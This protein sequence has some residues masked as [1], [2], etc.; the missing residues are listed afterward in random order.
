MREGFL[1]FLLAGVLLA[2]PAFAQETPYPVQSSL[3]AA[4]QLV[5][6]CGN[7]AESESA[8]I[9]ALEVECPGLRSALY[10]LG[11]AEYLPVNWEKELDVFALDEIV[12]LHDR[13]V[14]ESSLLGP[15]PRSLRRVLE[16]F[17]KQ[18][19]PP[20]SLWERFKTWLREWLAGEESR[21]STWF[22]EFVKRHTVPDIVL[23][24]IVYA[25]LA[26]VVGLAIGI[27]VAELRAAGLFAK[28]SASSRVATNGAELLFTPTVTLTQVDAAPVIERPALLLRLLVAA[29]IDNRQ[30]TTERGLTHRELAQ[31]V[32]FV[33]PADR[34][35]FERLTRLAE[36]IRYGRA[37]DAALIEESQ[38]VVAEARSLYEQ[39]RQVK[40]AP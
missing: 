28:R 24:I 34:G 16:D 3:Q 30:L 1:R 15:D 13:Y 39:V 26:T 11:V 7:V 20:P 29:L 21:G 10:R 19:I 5:N 17:E 36:R 14:K 18:T 4:R 40:S 2:S 25:L 35:S 8:G 38:P 32:K 31:R 37:A 12:V 6:D 27:V 22:D 9:E 33:R 23:K